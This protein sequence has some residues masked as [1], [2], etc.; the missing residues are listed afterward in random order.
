MATIVNLRM[1]TIFF[2]LNDKLKGVL[3][4]SRSQ[5]STTLYHLRD[6]VV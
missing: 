1:E 5:F 3:F 2:D 6:M 4:I